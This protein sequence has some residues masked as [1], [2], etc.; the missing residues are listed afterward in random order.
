MTTFRLK[1]E[2][3]GK[4]LDEIYKVFKFPEMLETIKTVMSTGVML[5][6]EIQT[7]DLNRFHVN[8][9]PYLIRK[10][11]HTKGVIMTFVDIPSKIGESKEPLHLTAEHKVLINGVAHDIKN[12]MLGLSLTL[13]MLTKLPDNSY[14]QKSLLLNAEKSLDDLKTMTADLES[15]LAR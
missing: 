13:Q 8:I 5:D 3:I 7:A 9:L 12:L 4:H 1:Q 15:R 14:Q 6:K 11:N 10:R 2:Y